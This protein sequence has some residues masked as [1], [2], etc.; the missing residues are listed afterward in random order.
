[1]PRLSRRPGRSDTPIG[2]H[3]FGSRS[4]PLRAQRD[5]R[6]SGTS[7]R[8][9]L[10]FSAGASGAGRFRRLTILAK[11]THTRPI[12]R[13]H[14]GQRHNQRP[15]HSLSPIGLVGIRRIENPSLSAIRRFPRKSGTRNWRSGPGHVGRARVRDPDTG[16][17]RAPGHDT[18]AIIAWSFAPPPVVMVTMASQRFH[19]GRFVLTPRSTGRLINKTV[20]SCMTR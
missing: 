20:R 15:R 2:R 11:Q 7:G 4:V 17:C 13:S 8:G 5:A 18:I 3:L 12:D 6:E 14:L 1:M 10:R 19:R 16:R 9:P